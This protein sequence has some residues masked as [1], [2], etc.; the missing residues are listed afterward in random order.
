MTFWIVALA[1]G[2]IL[3]FFFFKALTL[4]APQIKDE[5]DLAVYKQ[6]LVEV[7]RDLERGIIAPDEADRLKTEIS[8]RI[9]ALDKHSD[10]LAS[11]LSGREIALIGAIFVTV[12][13]GGGAALYTH[14]GQPGYSDLSQNDRIE[15][16]KVRM[17]AR[18]SQTEVWE[19]MPAEIELNTPVG[20]MAEMVKQLRDKVA[21]R[22]NDLEGHILLFRIEAGLGNFRAAAV[23]KERVLSLTA[24]PTIEDYFDYAEMLI[25]SVNGY[26]SPQAETALKAVLSRD[27]NHG[28]ALYYSG[29]MMAQNDRPDVAFR[30]WNRLLRDG[31]DDAPWLEPIRAQIPE[32]AFLA[33]IS[34]F[35]LPQPQLKGPSAEDIAAASDMTDGDRMD[36]IRG[37]VSQLSD[38][39]ATQGGSP[40]EW[41]RLINALGVLGD[42]EQA[43]AIFANAKEVF[44]S[45]MG[46]L[47]QV[48]AAAR[49]IG[50]AE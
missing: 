22:P 44:A 41:A 25:L 16:A 49:Q 4:R 32:L 13:L 34:D 37:M 8:R 10:D 1:S 21:T 5:T 38:R 14:L 35:E 50:I 3:A 6:Q 27:P 17:E 29:H 2:A 43:K 48:T 40:S 30:L 46:A 45:N 42:V 7:D 20:E 26:V 15:N 24:E 39:L 23:A 33:G 19:K 9:L 47:D 18:P 12:F 11:N 36:M 28:P 31:P